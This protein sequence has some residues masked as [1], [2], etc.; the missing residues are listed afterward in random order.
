MRLV[1]RS[2][3]A[4]S[5]LRRM[6]VVATVALMTLFAAPSCAT[7]LD[8]LVSSVVRIKTFINPDG[9]SVSNLG[10]DREGSGIVI[11]ESGL[12]LTIGYLM[13]EAHAA[14][15]VTNAG[16]TLPATVVGYDHE[17]GFG[18]LRTLEPI[19]TKPLP[20]GKSADVKEQ[21]RALVVSFGGADMVVP[22]NVVS[23]RVFAGSWEYLV[24]DALFTSPP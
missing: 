3:D 22:V 11:D 4:G 14:E 2:R 8:D 5:C 13:V 15:I 9:T 18:L 10:K 16:R 21:D 6:V 12:V 23:K 24:P 20:I 7:T 1:M 17:T 19:K